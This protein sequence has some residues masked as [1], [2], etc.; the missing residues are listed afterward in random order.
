MRTTR[1]R[2]AQVRMAKVAG[3]LSIVLAALIAIATLTVPH[4]VQRIRAN[5]T[6]GRLYEEPVAV[7]EETGEEVAGIDWGYWA[8]VNPDIVG[9]ITIP[10]TPIDYPIV[11]ARP[12]DPTHYLN[13]DVFGNYNIYGCVYVD[14][15]CTF[16][17]ANVIIFAHN[18]GNYDDSMFTTL[19]YYLDPA[20]LA[21][22]EQVIIQTPQGTRSLKVRAA[23][24][25]SPYGYE[26]RVAFS[27]VEGLRRFYLEVWE[28]ADSR[29][30]EPCAEE[31]DQLFTLITCSKG[32]AV[33]AV[34]YVG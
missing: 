3:G 21:T 14:S 16:G 19:T 18:M 32:G 4:E 6:Q 9:W 23:E 11:Q 20:Y 17:S 13:Y 12:D 33:R 34:V 8:S 2:A 28:G 10:G 25:V 1:N 30:A 15:A 27:S 7:V 22:H 31:I 5:P 26:K 29:S 24:S